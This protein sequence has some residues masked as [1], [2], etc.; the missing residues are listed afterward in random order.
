MAIFDAERMREHGKRFANGF[1]AGQKT[2]SIIG[3]VVVL[4]GAF[5]F[6]KWAATS[7]YAALYTGLDPADAGEVTT[8][9]DARGIDYK[10]SDGGR[11]IMVPR[12]DVYQTRLDLSS[13][14]LPNG[15]DSYALIDEEGIT[16]SEFRQRVD[17]QRAL[18]GELSKTIMA[19]DGVKSATVNLTIPKQD[20]FVGADESKTS[21]AVLVETAGG[22]L[23]SSEQVQSIVH[24]VSSSVAD[25]PPDQVTVTDSLGN[26]L[27]APGREVNASSEQL[28]ERTA[29][30]DSLSADIE[31]LVAASLGPGHAA[32]TVTADLDFDE[33]TTEKVTYTNPG[34]NQTPA[35]QS[36]ANETYTSEGGS[37]GGGGVV[38][39]DG[40]TGSGGGTT[41]YS[42]TETQAEF[43]INS[44]AEEVK[45][46]PGGINR[47]NVAMIV[48][49]ESIDAGD[50]ATWTQTISAAAG[51]DTTRGDV[52]K[53][54]RTPFDDTVAKQ[55]EKDLAAAASA[56]GKDFMMTIVRY[57]VTLLIVGIVLFLAWRSVKK[58]QS[59]APMRVPLDLRELEADLARIGGS[60]E[61]VAV[62]AAASLPEAPIQAIEPAKSVVE[63]QISDLI[64]RQPDEVAQTLRSWL[65]DRRA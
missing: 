40:S 56:D 20:V 23:L 55:A 44:V 12:P 45:R 32:V 15:G 57:V 48:D 50:I 62:S 14:G 34:G 6:T 4:G 11:T 60:R 46:A 25:L 3:L 27:A 33:S 51:I 19:L 52:I 24:L 41:D 38:G 13:Q 42:K 49:E 30:E 35:S 26:L 21:A 10:L 9:L 17:Y 2:M 58:S 64:E 37:G 63:A 59:F 65:A 31:S 18:Q 16:T 1:T 43:A 28:E 36:S 7:D 5:F 8:E 22:S 47:L 54:Q 61:L 29:F 39:P 53:I